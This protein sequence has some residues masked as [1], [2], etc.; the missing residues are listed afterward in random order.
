MKRGFFWASMN[1][2]QLHIIISQSA[3]FQELCFPNMRS[4]FIGYHAT[5]SAFRVEVKKEMNTGKENDKKNSAHE[6]HSHHQQEERHQKINKHS[7][8]QHEA[9]TKTSEKASTRS[10]SAQEPQDWQNEPWQAHMNYVYEH[11]CETATDVEILS[12]DPRVFKPTDDHAASPTIISSRECR[13]QCQRTPGCVGWHFFEKGAKVHHWTADLVALTRRS[14]DSST[15][16]DSGDA[17]IA[18]F[19][20]E[21]TFDLATEAQCRFLPS[22]EKEVLE[23]LVWRRNSPGHESGF[24]SPGV[25]LH[26]RKADADN[27]WTYEKKCESKHAHLTVTGFEEANQA[28]LE[29]CQ[30]MCETSGKCFFYDFLGAGPEYGAAT[31]ATGGADEQNNAKPVC[32]IG[33]DPMA[34]VNEETQHPGKHIGGR[35]GTWKTC[36]GVPGKLHTL[37]DELRKKK[38]P[39]NMAPSPLACALTCEQEENCHSFV[40]ELSTHMCTLHSGPQVE[41]RG[42]PSNAPRKQGFASG[43]CHFSTQVPDNAHAFFESVRARSSDVDAQHLLALTKTP[44][45]DYSEVLQETLSNGVTSHNSVSEIHA[46]LADEIAGLSSA[47]SAQQGSTVN[48][49]STLAGGETPTNQTENILLLV[50][51]I[52]SVIFL[53]GGTIVIVRFCQSDAD[54]PFAD[55]IDRRHPENPHHHH[56]TRRYYEEEQ[57][58]NNQNYDYKPSQAYGYDE[59]GKGDAAGIST[60]PNRAAQLLQ[61]QQQQRGPSVS[62]RGGGPSKGGQK[63]GGAGKY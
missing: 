38:I 5:V 53:V 54:S 10:H 41:M 39:D 58:E 60:T 22:S 36:A 63:D 13:Q 12:Q 55:V 25:L 16:Y 50:S 62:P 15:A 37:A 6:D 56:G 51:L 35:C 52:V 48:K 21:D 42:L 30:R 27:V 23:N 44:S 47:A 14:A 31:S 1:H 8:E 11:Q 46:E 24:C 9:S 43:N 17:V 2:L 4:A 59:V 40:Y 19:L 32:Q 33:T 29:M 49:N 26:K 45:K 61:Q 20:G 3:L 57:M 28:T 34:A 18:E 7:A